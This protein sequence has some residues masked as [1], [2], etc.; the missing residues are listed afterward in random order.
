MKHG[1]EKRYHDDYQ[2]PPSSTASCHVQTEQH[3]M[4]VI[5]AEFTHVRLL[6]PAGRWLYKVLCHVSSTSTKFMQ[7]GVWQ[8]C[9]LAE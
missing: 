4:I 7:C 2:I 5:C 1:T 8:R 6:R 3:V 9:T